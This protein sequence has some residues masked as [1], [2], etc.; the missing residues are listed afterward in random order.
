MRVLF[1]EDEVDHNRKYLIDFAK[2]LGWTDIH[3]MTSL[4]DVDKINEYSI[5]FISNSAH[6]GLVND[7]GSIKIPLISWNHSMT[8]PNTFNDYHH[9]ALKSINRKY[10]DNITLIDPLFY[11]TLF[12]KSNDKTIYA[13]SC[14]RMA[15]HYLNPPKISNRLVTY[16]NH[17]STS[18]S[19]I[20]KIV[21][22]NEMQLKF[23]IRLHPCYSESLL[24]TPS[25][26]IYK[27]KHWDSEDVSE[28][29]KWLDSNKVNYSI[30]DMELMDHIDQSLI[31]IFD[32]PSGTLS[33][34]LARSVVY[35]YRKYL[36]LH[37]V[38][39]RDTFYSDDDY[40]ISQKYFDTFTSDGSSIIMIEDENS[41]NKIKKIF[42][43]H[44]SVNEFK[45]YYSNLINRLL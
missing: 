28:L 4:N 41:M 1:I 21:K 2:L 6:R 14:Y 11:K 34:S 36:I 29:F 42:H 24:S 40:R 15:H 25:N 45:E 43:L 18:L 7:I 44:N 9:K 10:L 37:R 27:Y 3:F 33:E 16:Y 13:E 39:G 8:G 32:G 26:P 20:Q 31:S 12:N 38:E 22:N 30:N 5:A 23:N 19:D 35:D 17:W